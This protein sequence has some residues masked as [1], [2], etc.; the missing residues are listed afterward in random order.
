METKTKR[1]S[2]NNILLGASRYFL[3]FFCSIL[4]FGF[5]VLLGIRLTLFQESYMEKKAVET[6]YYEMLTKEINRQ[7]Q[8]I[9]L[10]S[11][12]DEGALDNVVQEELVARNTRNYFHVAYNGG[13]FDFAGSDEIRQTVILDVNK[14][15]QGKKISISEESKKAIEKLAD[16]AVSTTNSYIRIPFLLDYGKRVLNFSSVLATFL[17]V[18]GACLVVVN[19]FLLYLLHKSWHRYFRFISY[20]FLG[21]GLMLLVI[22]VGVVASGLIERVN[23]K[24][25]ALYLFLTGYLNGFFRTFIYFGIVVL[26]IGI[27]L[28]IISEVRRKRKISLPKF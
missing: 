17:I 15:A 22:P 24:S 28:F 16:E 26:A 14:F 23:I 5:L 3:S 9:G 21:S 27:V 18:S 12:I 6:N 25:K 13:D 19:I 4:L 7:I 20:S 10:G 2:N 8:D 1:S 11:N